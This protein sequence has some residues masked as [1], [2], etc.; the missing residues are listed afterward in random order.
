MKRL[1]SFLILALFLSTN[2]NAQIAAWDFFGQ[3]SPATVAATTFNT[4]LSTASS[5]NLV[6]RGSGAALSSGS[7][8]FRTVG[9][10]NNGIAVTNT[11][12]FQITLKPLSGFTMSLSTIDAKLIG[13][14]TFCVTPGVASQFAYSLDGTTFTLI[15]SPQSSIGT[16]A[17]LTQISLSGITAL[18][19]VPSTT[20]VTLRYYAS[21]QTSTGGWGFSSAT[22]GTNGLAIGGALTPTTSMGTNTITAGAATEPLTIPSITNTNTAAALNFDV[23]IQDDG[24][25][26]ANDALNTLISQMIFTQGTGNDVA[27]WTNAI[28]GAEL[29]DGTNTAT[30][31]VGATTITFTSIPTTSGALGN[32]AD[33][34]TKTYTLKVWLKTTVTNPLTIDGQNLV[35][36]LQSSGIT[37]DVAGSQFDSAQDQNSGANNNAIAVVATKLAFIAQPSNT[38]INVAMTPPPTVN[39]NDV[40]GNRDI[41]FVGQI[42]VA[43]LGTLSGGSVISN[44]TAGIAGF[45]TLVHTANGTALTLTATATSLADATST[46]FDIAIVTNATD[47]FRSNV[48]SG[49]WAT[50]ATWESS[51]DNITWMASTLSPTSAANTITI[52]NGHTITVNTAQTIDQTVVESGG[53]MTHSGGAL[54]INDGSTSDDLLIQMGGVFTQNT[55]TY[56]TIAT[57]ANFRINTGGTLN[58][59]SGNLTYANNSSATIAA[60]TKWD[61]GSICLFNTSAPALSGTVVFPNATPTEIP[62]LRVNA[63]WGSAGGNSPTT[64]NGLLDVRVSFTWGGTTTAGTK[65]FR[66]GVTNTGSTPATMTQT[67]G[68]GA[69]VINGNSVEMGGTNG[70]LTLAM[71]AGGLSINA[72][73]TTFTSNVISTGTGTTTFAGTAAQSVFGNGYSIGNVTINNTNGLIVASPFTINGIL[74]FLAGKITT[75]TNLLTLGNAATV[76]GANSSNYVE[77]PMAKMTNSTT[78]F[79]FP[80]G[81]NGTTRSIGIAPAAATQTTY[82]AEF[83]NAAP[84]N[85]TAMTAP[86]VAVSSLEYF[87]LAASPATPATVSLE[88]NIPTGFC[89]ATGDLTLAHFTGGNWVNESATATGSVTAGTVTTAGPVTSYSPFALG[90]TSI[91]SSPLPIELKSFTASN[92]GKTNLV[93]WETALEENIRSFVVE[94]SE[95]GTNWSQ[96]AQTS[97]NTSK[98]YTLT[99][100][101]P[102]KTTYYRLLSIENDGHENTSKIISVSFDKNLNVNIISATNDVVRLNIFSQNEDDAT[103]SI[104]DMNGRILTSQKAYLDAKNN[105]IDLSTALQSGMYVVKIS[106]TSGEQASKVLNVR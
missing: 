98:R 24:A 97:P 46:T 25:T 11:D 21:G 105:N 99:D 58:I 33:N 88:Y 67:V 50:A 66:N 86:I 22:T 52:R 53:N 17:T 90:S 7:N 34:A 44:A 15:G 29:T 18:Q 38:N 60:G 80:I 26:P 103:I 6:T 16:P 83:I 43:S 30:G 101:N 32:I 1:I 42:E 49:N 57:G 14:A 13:T 95:N 74:T 106:T 9:F 84:S 69:W 96:M 41:D 63:A 77:G 27:T 4:N 92:N 36:R 8:S 59:L 47:Y 65:T 10:Q 54:T 68:T 79:I 55:T 20:T 102:F 85:R 81:K 35:F 82:T 104:I 93:Q 31:T 64:I 56:A 23:A 89:T 2:T 40:N 39:A 12:Y 28:A 87:D 3:S 75:T 61:N 62:I 78:P 51:A 45:S 100:N 19:N 91:A 70:L 94:K 76:V 72:P 5:A 71:G 73:T 48:A 37:A